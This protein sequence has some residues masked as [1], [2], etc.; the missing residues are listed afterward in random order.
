MWKNVILAQPCTLQVY[1]HGWSLIN[2]TYNIKWFDGDQLPQSV[3]LIL[4]G[5]GLNTGLN[6]EGQSS[7]DESDD[8]DNE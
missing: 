8:D 6:A 3:I 1:D 4:N 7:S 5:K 2:G